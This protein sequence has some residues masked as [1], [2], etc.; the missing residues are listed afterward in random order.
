MNNSNKNWQLINSLVE[1][2]SPWLKLIAERY[3]DD[4]QKIIDYWRVEKEHSVIIIVIH[5]QQLLLP[6]PIYRPGVNTITL[7]FA[8]GRLPSDRSPLAIVPTILQ[9]ELGIDHTDIISLI[10]IN[11]EGWNIN[12]SFSNQQLYGFVANLADQT[13]ID[14]SKIGAIYPINDQSIQ[15]LL[16]QLTCLQCRSLLLEWY[17]NRSIN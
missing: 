9:R 6:V 12:S 2:S 16:K 17:F 4:Q 10:P 13:I 3:Q 8:G 11:S 14:Q 5:Q 15:L 7:D 1:I